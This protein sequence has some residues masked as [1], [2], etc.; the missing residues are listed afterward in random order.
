MVI[1]IK[2][3]LT[4]IYKKLSD[5]Q[6]DPADYLEPTVLGISAIYNFFI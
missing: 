3:L 2:K 1:I 6:T 4:S 5:K